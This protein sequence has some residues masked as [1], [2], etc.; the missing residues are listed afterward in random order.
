MVIHLPDQGYQATTCFLGAPIIESSLIAS[1]PCLKAR[2]VPNSESVKGWDAG[3]EPTSLSSEDPEPKYPWEK[4][5]VPSD[6]LRR[7]VYEIADVR[8][9]EVRNANLLQ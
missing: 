4:P 2:I 1:R 3:T 6:R 8:L 7:C 5:S 9:V